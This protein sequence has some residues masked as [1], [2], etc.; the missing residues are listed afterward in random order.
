MRNLLIVGAG[1]FGREVFFWAKDYFPSSEYSFKGFIA[2]KVTDLKIYD[3]NLPVFLDEDYKFQQSDFCL[4]AIGNPND[5]Q[6]EANKIL[7]SNAS[8]LSLIHPTAVV[9][10]NAKLGQ[11][12]IICPY[13]VVSSNTYIGDFVALN[14]HTTIGHDAEIGKFSTL[15]PKVSIGGFSKVGDSCFLGSNSSVSPGVKIANNSKVSANSFVAKNVSENSLVVGVP[16]KQYP[17]IY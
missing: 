17:N 8:F 14:L 13:V 16:G 7:R 11:G 1:G 12:V 9:V 15:S 6:T 5:K 10:P 3:I 2:N 4:M